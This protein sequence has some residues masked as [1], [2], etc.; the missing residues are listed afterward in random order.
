[1][2]KK[3]RKHNSRIDLE[4][5][6]RILNKKIVVEC[7]VTGNVDRNLLADNIACKLQDKYNIKQ[8]ESMK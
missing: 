4:T 7:E 8:K 3:A 1:M 6:R 5:M 2:V